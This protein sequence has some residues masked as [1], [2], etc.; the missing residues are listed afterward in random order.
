MSRR[1][2]IADDAAYMR[3]MLRDILTEGGYTVVAEASDGDEAVAEFI[4]HSPDL[5]TLDIVMPRKSGLEALRE[6]MERDPGACV[7]MCSA[8]GQ[9]ALVRDMMAAGARGYLVKP[10]KPDQVLDVVGGALAKPEAE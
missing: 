7:V 4:E 8:L 9:E 5:V 3:E 10:F 1:V 2:L 6:I